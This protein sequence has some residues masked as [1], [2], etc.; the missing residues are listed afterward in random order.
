MVPPASD[1][2]RQAASAVASVMAD[3]FPET[4]L[5]VTIQGYRFVYAAEGVRPVTLEVGPD[6]SLIRASAGS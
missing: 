3:A 4:Q 5:G 1:G 2:E 6:G